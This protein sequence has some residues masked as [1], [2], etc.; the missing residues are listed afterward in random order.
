MARLHTVFPHIRPAGIIFSFHFHSK[1][2]VQKTKGKH[3]ETLLGGV[4]KLL[5]IKSLLAMP[6][7]VWPL[8]LKQ[9][10]LPIF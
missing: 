3:C 6:S 9:T 4:N 1:V 7:N 2:T 8:Q 10:F 5:K